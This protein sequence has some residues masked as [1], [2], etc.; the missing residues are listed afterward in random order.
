MS[1]QLTALE[2]HE[3]AA[4]YAGYD[5]VKV[6]NRTDSSKVHYRWMKVE[7]VLPTGAV[8]TACFTTKSLSG[9]CECDF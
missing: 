8:C 2:Y 5:T 7:K 6:A 9:N 1:A 3:Q 4:N